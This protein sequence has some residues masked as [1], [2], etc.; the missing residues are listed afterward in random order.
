MLNDSEKKE[1]Q[2]LR[3][4]IYC[5]LDLFN[6]EFSEEEFDEEE[7]YSSPSVVRFLELTSRL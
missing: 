2:E 3:E 1:L 4:C 5:Y 6:Q 7:F